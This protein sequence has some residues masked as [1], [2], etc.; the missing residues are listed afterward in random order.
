MS[1]QQ[2]FFDDVAGLL[3]DTRRLDETVA[4]WQDAP[5]ASPLM[6]VG[7]QFYAEGAQSRRMN[8]LRFVFPKLARTLSKVQLGLLKERFLQLPS[9]GDLTWSRNAKSVLDA[10]IALAGEQQLPK[11]A[12]ELASHEWMLFDVGCS[13]VA[14][15]PWKSLDAVT[16]NPTLQV[17]EHAFA[18]PAWFKTF[19]SACGFPV[20]AE[21]PFQISYFLKPESLRPAWR[22]L[23]PFTLAALNIVE[24][25]M[26]LSDV[27]SQIGMD[28]AALT[29]QM[30]A[31]ANTGL[32][33]AEG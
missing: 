22:V 6:R 1:N 19:G 11:A 9:G 15:G 3:H 31:L 29:S 5:G 23:D 26:A 27:A 16:I 21:A 14:P 20:E 8:F 28:L 12:L 33:V 4:K 24:E 18:W 10:V 13:D 32:L 30:E 2:E 25:K 17:L 7:L